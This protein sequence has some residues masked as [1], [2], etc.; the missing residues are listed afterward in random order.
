VL[1]SIGKKEEVMK[2]TLVLLFSL[3][4]LSIIPNGAS[5]DFLGSDFLGSID[6]SSGLTGTGSWK[7]SAS[8]GWKVSY[9]NNTG[10]WSYGYE[11]KVS[12]KDISHLIFEVSENFANSNVTLLKFS[13]IKL[14]SS[15]YEIGVFGPN[16]PSNPGIPGTMTGLKLDL[17]ALDNK[18]PGTINFLDF[19]WTIVTDRAP[20]WGNFYAKDGRVPGTD[21][22]VFAHNNNFVNSGNRPV[23]DPLTY[24]INKLPPGVI[25]VPDTTTTMV[26]EPATMLLL[27]FGL[28]GMAFI[29]RRKFRK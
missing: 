16:D 17:D 21:D 27:G 22:W 8:V 15:D 24:D 10:L 29:G 2:K 23:F 12:S 13:D 25:L 26:P 14:S 11:F 4:L 6:S 7:T 3:L 5:A 20:M 28:M 1:G 9:N 19:A 18:Y